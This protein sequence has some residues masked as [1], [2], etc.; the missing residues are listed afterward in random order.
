M[1]PRVAATLRYAAAL[2][3]GAAMA[4]AFA[5]FSLATLAVAGLA[6]I[7]YLIATARGG[8]VLC[9]GYLFGLA[10]VGLGVYWIFVS[11]SR[12]GGGPLAASIV[13][14]IF[15]A[16]F[17]LYPMLALWLGARLSYRR[18]AWAVLTTLP[19][20]WVAMEWIRSWLFTGTTWLAVGYTQIDR[21]LAALAPIL[22]TFG[23]SLVVVMLAGSLAAVVMRPTRGRV[24]WAAALLVVYLGSGWLDNIPWTRPDGE[25]LELAMIQGNLPPDQKW[26]DDKRRETLRYY[27]DRSRDHFGKPLIIWPE[28]AVPAFYRRVSEQWLDPLA[29]E[30]ARAGSTVITGVPVIGDDRRITRSWPWVSRSGPIASATWFLSGNMCRSVAGWAAPWTSSG[31][32]WGI[33]GPAVKPPCCRP[34]ASRSGSR[35]VT[36]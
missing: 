8:R 23:L 11:V 18:P 10:Y 16:L 14:P 29:A 24:S 2:A 35:F 6:V 21:P 34:P 30:A 27:T 36:R 22:G 3:A 20:T 25:P 31:R 5:P 17:A 33:S 12:F 1:S 4:L 26:R 7:F 19:L 32:P 13:T 15:I 28:T 9:L